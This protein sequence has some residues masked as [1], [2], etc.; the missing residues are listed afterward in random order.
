MAKLQA[1][2]IMVGGGVLGTVCMIV[3]V[4]CVCAFV[5]YN[6][7]KG[8]NEARVGSETEGGL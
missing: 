5:C 3:D 7:F 4:K 8:F 2:G 1:W 6:E